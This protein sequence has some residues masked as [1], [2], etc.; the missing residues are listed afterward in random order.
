MQVVNTA[1]LSFGL[2]GRVFHA[3]FLN[4]HPGFRLAG[5]WER[6]GRLIESAYP[7]SK[8]YSSLEEILTDSSID[9]VVVNTPTSTHATF[10]ADALNAGK[11]VVVEKAFTTTAQ[12]ASEL[13]TLSEKRGKVLSVYQ[14]RRWDSDF[15]T[16][17]KVITEGHLGQLV[18]ATIAY[19]RYNPGLS[20]KRHRETPGPGAGN[21]MDLGPHCIDEALVLFGIPQQVF[22]DIRICR[23]GSQVDDYFD[24][25]LYYPSMRVRLKS[26]YLVREQGPAF[27][28]HGTNG[29]LTKS[30]SDVQQSQLMDGVRPDAPDYGAEPE[31]SYGLLHTSVDGKSRQQRIASLPGNYMGYYNQLYDAI[32][33]GGKIPVTGEEG[34]MVMKVIEAARKSHERKVVV[35]LN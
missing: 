13:I 14:N 27:V 24:I 1:L 35:D 3:P 16:V 17:R 15:M 21:L 22:A 18:E 26:S 7:G 19:E 6:T 28:I 33:K 25:L 34:L 8:R 10:A 30:R 12:E 31:S 20:P 11:H 2:S 23:E 5:C 9:L 32:A 4:A 29:S